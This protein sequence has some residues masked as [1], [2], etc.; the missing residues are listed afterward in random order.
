MRLLCKHMLFNLSIIS[1]I[2]IAASWTVCTIISCVPKGNIQTLT[3]Y[4]NEKAFL[5]AP[6]PA[7]ICFCRQKKMKVRKCWMPSRS[8]SAWCHA[9]K[10]PICSSSAAALWL[11]RVKTHPCTRYCEKMNTSTKV[12][13]KHSMYRVQISDLHFRDDIQV[14]SL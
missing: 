7:K 11:C 3:L 6:N 10:D 9:F 8:D 4:W 2:K 5:L 13:C 12:P 1:Q 14:P